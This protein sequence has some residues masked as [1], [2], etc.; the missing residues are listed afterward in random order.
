M[1]WL[2]R[3]L[4]DSGPA[5]GDRRG[6]CAPGVVAARRASSSASLVVAV[7]AVGR[8]RLP[9]RRPAA[10]ARRRGQLVRGR[11]R[12]AG[13]RSCST[14]AR[15]RVL[16]RGAGRRRARPR[17]HHGAG[18]RAQP[19]GRTRACS[20]SPAARASAR[21]SRSS[22]V[23]GASIWVV[24][25]GRLPRRAGHVRAGLRAGLATRAELRPARARRHRRL[26]RRDLA[27]HAD[28]RA[29]QP[30]EHDDGADL[31][32]R[33]RPTGGPRRRCG[34]SRSRCVVLTPLVVRW[35]RDLDVLSVDDDVARVLGVQLERTRLG[36]ARRDRAA[37]GRVGVR[38][39]RRRVRR[40]DRPAPGPL[41]RRLAGTPA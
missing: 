25:G 9:R 22:C 20:A 17:R 33:A 8:R 2:A 13:R 40:P 11:Q 24:S 1:V 12:P 15:P 36:A 35:R 5:R 27:H 23:P 32:V 38:D 37:H 16:G 7:V 6:R 3:R 10:A 14:S 30:V 28:R 4:R 19:A 34:R 18:R 26:G 41:A 29:D 21:C 31:A 39:R